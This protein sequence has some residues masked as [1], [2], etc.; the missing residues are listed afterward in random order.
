MNP[1]EHD[2]DLQFQ[3][4]AR[5]R[6]LR[7][8]RLPDRDLW[9]GIAARIAAQP[10]RAS[11]TSAARRSRAARLAPWALAASLA[12]AVGVAW[13]PRPEPMGMRADPAASLITREAEAMTREYDAAMRELQAAGAPGVAGHD[14]LLQ[15]DRSAAQIRTALARDPGARFLLDRLR[16]TYEKRLELTQRLP[17][18]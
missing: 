7:N 17:L 14:A 11:G 8:E 13:Q 18:T 3:L 9:P 5:L 15:L 16:D 10:A 4:R 12:F 1:K 6:G 2:D